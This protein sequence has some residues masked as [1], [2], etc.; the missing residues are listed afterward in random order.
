MR[1]IIMSKPIVR[2]EADKLDYT[3]YLLP[4]PHLVLWNSKRLKELEFGISFLSVAITCIIILKQRK[5][6]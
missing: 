6:E 5:E 4:C 2:I 1:G 3:W